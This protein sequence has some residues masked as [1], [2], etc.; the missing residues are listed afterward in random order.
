VSIVV[1]NKVE[2]AKRS[3]GLWTGSLLIGTGLIL[4][5]W[6]CD[7]QTI[8][9]PRRELAAAVAS[10]RVTPANVSLTVGQTLQLSAILGDLAGNMLPIYMPALNV[11]KTS[12]TRPATVI[13]DSM[14][15]TGRLVT[16]RSNQPS[17]VSVDAKGLVTALAE[18]IATITA[19]SEGRSETVKITIT[20]RN[21]PLTVMPAVASLSV[22]DKLQLK[23]ILPD[24]NGKVVTQ[25]IWWHSDKPAQATVSQSGVVDAIKAGSVTITAGSYGQTGAAIVNIAPTTTINGLDFPGTAGVHTT[26][27]FEFATP[28]AAYPATYIWRVYPRQQQSYYTAFFWGNKGAFYPSNT[29]YG[30]HPYPDWKTAFQHFWEIA[31]PPGRD[32]VSQTH[33]VYDRWYIQVAVCRK[34]GDSTVNEFYWDWPDTTKV[35]RHTGKQYDDPPAPA[36]VVGDAPWNPGNEVWDGVLRGFQFYDADLTQEEIE[37]EI[38]SPGSVRTPWYLNLNPTPMD[39]SDHSGSGH[40]PEWVGIARPSQWTGTLIGGTIVRTAVAPQ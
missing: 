17:L 26:M 16:W 38:A 21:A 34:S 9:H 14:G 3:L 20:S 27:R 40:H 8:E 13:G 6:A 25:P 12:D 28:L 22:G 36:L 2:I 23:A 4:S 7:Q 18:G 30:F 31:A 35:V 10:I 32:F 1:T 5:I 33:V 15:R 39:I 19:A 37:Q 29:Y 11:A 24:G